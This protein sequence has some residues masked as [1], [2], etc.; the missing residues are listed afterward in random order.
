MVWRDGG[1][2]GGSPLVIQSLPE[3]G[4]PVDGCSQT[5]YRLPLPVCVSVKFEIGVCPIA[6]EPESGSV[7]RTRIDDT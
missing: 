7:G 3:F 2:S 5:L 4:K 6:C 1:V